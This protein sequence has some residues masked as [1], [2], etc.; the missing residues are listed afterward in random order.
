MNYFNTLSELNNID[1]T[2]LSE[3]GTQQVN[4]FVS[5]VEPLLPDIKRGD[6]AKAAVV[7]YYLEHKEF[8]TDG[9]KN[10]LEAFM[11]QVNVSS[12]YISQVKKAKEFKA[13]IQ[14]NSFS[15]WVGEHPVS[16]QY[17]LSKADHNKL[18]NKFQTGEHCS[19]R[20]ARSYKVDKNLKPAE[21]PTPEIVE[22]VKSKNQELIDDESRIYINTI[23][24][25]ATALGSV[26][27]DLIA[28]TMDSV[29]RIKYMD[30]KREKQLRHL[31]KLCNEALNKPVY[32][33]Q[34]LTSYK[35]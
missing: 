17:E 31:I 12:G 13:G 23:S 20:E 15:K 16:V 30:P 22:E 7:D 4:D 2:N 14:N 8:Y 3:K 26:R 5:F 24:Q 1:A 6:A 9:A 29:S 34:P 10:L 21:H 25:A 35:S 19:F 32:V 27:G 11:T 28:A 33:P 18:I